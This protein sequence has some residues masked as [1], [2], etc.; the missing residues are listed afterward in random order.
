[1]FGISD[2]SCFSPN[3]DVECQTSPESTDNKPL[4]VSAPQHLMSGGVD[5]LCEILAQGDGIQNNMPSDKQVI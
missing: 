1:M 5:E 2:I 3:I 4:A